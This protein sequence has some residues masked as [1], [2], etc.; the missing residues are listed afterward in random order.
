MGETQATQG[1]IFLAQHYAGNDYIGTFSSNYSSGGLIIGYGA[2]GMKGQGNNKL[3]STLDNFSS[4]RGALRFGKGTL[5]F[6][7]T[8]TPTQA[9]VNEVLTVK[10]R[11]FVKE[12]GNVG[13]GTTTPSEKLEIDGNFRLKREGKIYWSWKDR[14]IEEYSSGGVSKMIRFKNSMGAN[15]SNP[16]GG[17]D[18]T[19]YQGKSVLRINNHRVGIGTTNIPSQ[20]KLAIAGKMIAEEVTVKLQSNWPDYVFTNDYKL[21]TLHEVEQH[22]KEKGHL[23]NIPSAKEV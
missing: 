22:I 11:F 4:N 15:Q 18:F 2:A 3:V 9:T 19:D 17:F 6:L 5:E 8:D 21:P 14:T 1:G 13:I 16:D 23:A 12:N 7:S 20:F 10:S